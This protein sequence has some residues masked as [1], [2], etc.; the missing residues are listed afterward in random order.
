M[1][2]SD[3]QAAKGKLMSTQIPEEKW[4]EISIDFVTD[5]PMTEGRK[6]GAPRATLA[7][8][9]AALRP[10]PIRCC[11]PSCSRWKRVVY[12]GWAMSST[13]SDETHTQAQGTGESRW[14]RNTS[15]QHARSTH[16]PC[17]HY[18]VHPRTLLHQS[19]YNREESECAHTSRTLYYIL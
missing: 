7:S 18:A 13:R 6:C 11:W 12:V 17:T 10:R 9:P 1:E 2:K 5:L 19:W 15:A 14:R 16:C 3:H 4:K 8:Y